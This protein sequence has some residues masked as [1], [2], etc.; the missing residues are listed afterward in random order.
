MLIFSRPV[1]RENK[2]RCNQDKHIFKEKG[3][4]HQSIAFNEKKKCLCANGNI[5]ENLFLHFKSFS[6]TFRAKIFKHKLMFLIFSTR[7]P[8][9]FDGHIS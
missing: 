8:F 7:E 5:N 2:G 4:V 1:K 3:S 9:Y 6:C